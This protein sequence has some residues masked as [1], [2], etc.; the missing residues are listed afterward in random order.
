MTQNIQVAIVDDQSLFLDGVVAMLENIEG[1]AVAGALTSGKACFEFLAKTTIDVLLLDINLP[2]EDGMEIC[3]QVRDQYPNI[4]IL[5]LTMH[6][7]GSFIQSMLDNGAR[8]YI[9]KNISRDELI[10]SIKTVHEGKSYFSAD[11]TDTIMSGLMSNKP[12]SAAVTPR[13]SRREKEV[14]Q[15]IADEFT[16]QEIADR[17]FVSLS[18][19]ESH[20][21][22]LLTKLEARNTAGLIRKA[23][24]QGLL[25]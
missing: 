6:N 5:A 25:E 8:G 24:E 12:A 22:N 1:I 15:L 21:R 2:S 3:K 17:L 13:L 18:T 20:R 4:N 7:E 11:V 9:L 19:V 14:L 16:T 10:R 23:V